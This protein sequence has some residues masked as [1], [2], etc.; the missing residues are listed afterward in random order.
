M[1]LGISLHYHTFRGKKH[2]SSIW[3]GSN[4]F[5]IITWIPN[6]QIFHA[7]IIY[8][9]AY[10][11]IRLHQ[12]LD[13]QFVINYYKYLYELENAANLHKFSLE[14][15]HFIIFVNLVNL[16]FFI[17]FHVII[18]SLSLTPHVSLELFRYNN[19]DQ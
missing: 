19:F 8:H 5:V 13:N 4:L 14:Y 10:K 16:I 1:E 12:F 7:S 15:T 3:Y 11:G 9:Q 6:P 2:L 18:S 17:I